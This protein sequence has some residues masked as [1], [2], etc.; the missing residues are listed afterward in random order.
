MRVFAFA[1][2]YGQDGYESSKMSRPFQPRLGVFS[3]DGFSRLDLVVAAAAK[4]G[5]RLILPLSNWWDEQGGCQW[6]VDQVYG[7]NPKQPKELFFSDPKV[8]EG[9]NDEAFFFFFFFP[10]L[11]LDLETEREREKKAHF[12]PPPPCRPFSKTSEQQQ[13]QPGQGGL[14]G[15]HLPRHHPQKPQDGRPA[16]L[17]G[18]GDHGVGADERAAA[19]QRLRQE[20]GHPSRVRDLGVGAGDGGVHQGGGREEAPRV[21]G[22]RG[23]AVGRQGR[24][25][26]RLDLD[27]R[28]HQG[29]R[30]RDKRQPP[31]DR[32]HDAARL[33]AQLGLLRRQVPVAAAE[34]RRGQGRAGGGGEQADRVGGACVRVCVCV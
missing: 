9:E 24:V 31:G 14:P 20:D 28:R 7:R 3:D 5:L 22:R 15:L 8:R 26:R 23:V 18:A 4:N 25:R 6:W 30:R 1:N 34:F 13:Q 10:E 19:V 27:Q 21:R 12:S 11:D 29:R 2:G 33:R 16:L 32:L 17:R